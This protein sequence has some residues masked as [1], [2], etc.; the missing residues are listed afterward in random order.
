[1]TFRGVRW[2]S[3]Q[4]SAGPGPRRTRVLEALTFV[5]RRS[6]RSKRRLSSARTVYTRAIVPSITASINF[7]QPRLI[8]LNG[9]RGRDALFLA[10]RVIGK[11]RTNLL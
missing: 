7:L 9:E 4:H 5:N 1:M 2:K 8:L 11:E 6:N 10:L 3:E